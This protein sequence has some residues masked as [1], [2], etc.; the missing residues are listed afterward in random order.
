[1]VSNKLPLGGFTDADIKITNININIYLT[2]I[3]RH[4]I[5]RI[6]YFEEWRGIGSS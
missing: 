3:S 2:K 4:N 5:Y 6:V 1:M